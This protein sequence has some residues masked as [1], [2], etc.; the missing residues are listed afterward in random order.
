[1]S[2]IISIV[3][4]TFFCQY[5]GALSSG[6]DSKR[7]RETEF[8]AVISRRV[9]NSNSIIQT[10]TQV[11]NDEGKSRSNKLLFSMTIIL[12]ICSSSPFSAHASSIT[13]SL[14]SAYAHRRRSIR[15]GVRMITN[16]TGQDKKKGDDF[17]SVKASVKVQGVPYMDA[18]SVTSTVQ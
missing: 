14:S 4:S 5:V 15:L 8:W 18:I 12:S 9:S 7:Y 11:I 6:G 16:V 2:S 3:L 1:M 10:G 13:P 17:S